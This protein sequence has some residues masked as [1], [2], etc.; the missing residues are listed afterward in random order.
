VALKKAVFPGDVLPITG[1]PKYNTEIL[2]T[3]AG[4][5]GLNVKVVPITE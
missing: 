5:A 3:P 1:N 2:L 4:G